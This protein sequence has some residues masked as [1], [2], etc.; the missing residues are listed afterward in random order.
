MPIK[1]LKN[2]LKV[3]NFRPMYDPNDRGMSVSQKM[4][5]ALGHGIRSGSGSFERPPSAP[6]PLSGS[7]ENNAE[8]K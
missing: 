5:M 4:A 3:K 2:A 1:N 6:E 8:E 7:M